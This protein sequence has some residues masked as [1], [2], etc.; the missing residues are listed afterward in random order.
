MLAIFNAFLKYNIDEYFFVDIC[1]E[2]TTEYNFLTQNTL[3][4]LHKTFYTK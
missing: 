3:K 4:C 2:I 1:K